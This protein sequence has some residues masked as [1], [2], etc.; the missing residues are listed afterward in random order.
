[1]SPNPLRALPKSA[2][3]SEEH[4][5]RWLHDFQAPAAALL[6]ARWFY[7]DEPHP[8][9]GF[10]S[11]VVVLVDPHDDATLILTC[12]DMANYIGAHLA[13]PPE[14]K[15]AM[16]LTLRTMLDSLA[17]D[18]AGNDDVIGIPAALERAAPLLKGFIVMCLDEALLQV[19]RALAKLRFNAFD[20]VSEEMLLLD[21]PQELIDEL[22]L[23]KNFINPRP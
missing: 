17:T 11:W 19:A 21:S 14:R 5:Q 1:M 15:E 8:R 20:S 3:A 18:V 10:S 23:V 22:A 4:R 7:F 9:D 16:T 13:V 12:L 2:A 6:A